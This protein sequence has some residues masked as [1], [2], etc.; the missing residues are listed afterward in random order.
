L[1]DL[2]QL[3]RQGV[4]PAIDDKNVCGNFCDYEDICGGKETATARSKRK[5]STD[6]KMDPLR[7]LKDHA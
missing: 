7:R 2:F 5:L 1:E 6:V 4:F 3:L